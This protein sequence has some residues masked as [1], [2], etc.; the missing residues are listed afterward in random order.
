MPAHNC[1]RQACRPTTSSAS[2]SPCIRWCFELTGKKEPKDGLEAKFSVYHGCAAGLLFGRAG[3]AGLPMMSS[4]APTSVSRGARWWRRWTRRLTRR[5][6][7]RDGR[8]QNGERREVH[9]E[10][11]IGSL[12]RPLSDADLE[13]KFTA[14]A[15]P[16]LGAAA[17]REL[18]AQAWSVGKVGKSAGAG[19]AVR[20]A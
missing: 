10:H 8:A 6:C 17:V 13:R 5:K 2:K 19:A 11:A 20:S 9:V 15:E 3:E 7:A 4:P 18:M 12:Q 16:V 14:L 1:G